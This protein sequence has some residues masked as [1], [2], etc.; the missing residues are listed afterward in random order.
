[1]LA[2][3]VA[4]EPWPSAWTSATA[5]GSIEA[6]EIGCGL[7]LAGLAALARGLRVAFSDY[8]PA[9]L[10]FVARSAAENGFDRARFTT[11]L[12]DWREPTAERFSVILGADVLYEARL[13]PL[14]A[15]VLATMLAPEGVGLIASPYRVAAAGFP[16]AVGSLGLVCRAEPA[17]A[18]TEDGPIQGTIYRVAR[19]WP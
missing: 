14:V 3:A 8:D 19:A 11:R 6:L 1:L 9:P 15:G 2:E 17:T 10:D 7:G 4:R 5:A 18:Q 16:A 12:L 13:V